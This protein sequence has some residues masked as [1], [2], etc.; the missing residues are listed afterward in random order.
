MNSTYTE[1]RY[2]GRYRDDCLS[3]WI[4]TRERLEGFFTFLNSLNDDL[5]FT[6]EVGGNE[7][8]F[9]DVKLSI[10]NG[11]IETSVYSKP[12]DSHLYLQAT[13]CHN[14]A[15]IK[16]IPKGVA[17]RL[18]RLCSTDDEFNNK[19][20]E[21]TDHLTL[22][23]YNKK[24]VD[25]AFSDIAKKTRNVARQTVSR[26]KVSNPVIFSTKYNPRGPN[27]KEIVKNQL[28][29]LQQDPK[30]LE[31]FPLDSIMVAN[32]RE[33][34][35][36]DLLFRSDPY[37]IKGDV[38]DFEPHGYS[39]CGRKCDSCNN[40]VLETSYIISKATGRKF[41][42]R[43]DTTCTTKNVIYVA[44]CQT[45]GK[46]GV[47]S[48]VSWKHRLSNYKSHI[49]KGIHSCRIS[50]HFIETCKDPTVSNLKFIIV[51]SINNTENLQESQIDELLLEKEKFW[52][53]TLI[54][55]HKGL[56]GTHDW[57]RK[58]RTEREKS[59]K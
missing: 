42:I 22:R 29:T 33:N 56:N 50:T 13:S 49:K 24:A 28:K 17:L 26:N 20:S 36:K 8:C 37:N 55:Q 5:K 41:H 39:K 25:T 27:V 38:S 53:G 23:G 2:F 45:C 14:K 12:T 31:L 47:G 30:L 40:Y 35:L 16:G 32:K 54:S 10:V 51:D 48:T 44:I 6:M 43:R 3:L 1:L 7:L 57:V 59:E 58:K 34:N 15:S 11:K 18:R 9:L 4:G 46:Q 19:A 52:I 21:Y